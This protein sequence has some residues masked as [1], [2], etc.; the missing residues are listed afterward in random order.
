M[1][2]LYTALLDGALYALIAVGFNIVFI[3]TGTFNFAQAQFVMLGTFV[4]WIFGIYFHMNPLLVILIGFAIG[5]VIGA[6]EERIAIRLLPGHGTHGELV[7]TV[8]FAVIIEG[9]A[10]ALFGSNPQPVKSFLTPDN[11]ITLFGG[12]VY[13]H[14]L[15]LIGVGVTVVGLAEL[16]SRRTMLGLASL[17][18][19]E[20][21]VAAVLRGINVGRLSI[22]AYVLACGMCVALGPIIAPSTYATATIGDA[23]NLKAFV[24]LAIGGFGSPKGALLGGLAAGLVEAYT[25]RYLNAGLGNLA[26]LVL[27]LVVLTIRPMG[28]FGERIERVV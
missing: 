19:A 1:T 24:A 11:A 6:V 18:S 2:T 21:R 9:L 17:A 7:T 28:L 8:G 10:I 25:G 22:G 12:R 3:A 5:G 23:L 13:P 16:L 27:L 14:E 26:V 15:L 4:A 20:N